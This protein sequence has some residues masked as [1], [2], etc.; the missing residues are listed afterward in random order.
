VPKSSD[1]WRQTVDVIGGA[2]S[3]FDQASAVMAWIHA[4]F[5]YQPGVTGV[6]A[7]LLDAF[8]LKRG[9]CQDF[10]H[11]MLGMCRVIGVAARYAS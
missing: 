8:E 4:E 5:T 7:T 1:V 11:V 2:T 3:V 9:V 10:T 6:N